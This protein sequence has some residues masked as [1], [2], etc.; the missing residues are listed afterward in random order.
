[1]KIR[2]ERLFYI[3]YVLALFSGAVEK[4]YI[5]E[6]F[7]VIITE[8]INQLFKI[9]LILLVAL[10]LLS[11][12][13]RKSELVLLGALSALL[14]AVSFGK[15]TRMLKCFLLLIACF[16]LDFKKILK[17]YITVISFIIGLAALLSGTGA[18]TMQTF[19]RGGGIRYALGFVHP[20][21]V[22]A[23]SFALVCSILC[24]GKIK[25][26]RGRYLI[27]IAITAAAYLI[28]DSNTAVAMTALVIAAIFAW[29]RLLPR[30]VEGKSLRRTVAAALVILFVLVAGLFFLIW[31]DPNLLI[32]ISPGLGTLRSRFVTAQYYLDLIGSSFFGRRFDDYVN[33][34]MILDNGYV[35]IYLQHGIIFT[36]VFFGAQILYIRE[37]LRKGEMELL[38]I[39]VAYLIYA[40]LE[41][42]MHQL[43]FNPFL[44]HMGIV[45]YEAADRHLAAKR[46]QSSGT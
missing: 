33:E 42:P 2:R 3:V 38:I 8:G 12:R 39:C 15:N 28:S 20:N 31:R 36:V 32:R 41:N 9:L 4:T 35:W 34:R 1:M 13:W 26:M 30:A 37:L 29:E 16:Q 25:E 44:I 22:G 17:I 43:F 14:F 11:R 21:N 7:P 24:L 19:E 45:F 46:S 6:F 18:I 5:Q 10:A 23:A 27:S 40:L